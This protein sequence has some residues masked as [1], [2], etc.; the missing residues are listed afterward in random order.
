MQVSNILNDIDSDK[1]IFILKEWCQNRNSILSDFLALDSFE[2]RN[3][4]LDQCQFYCWRRILSTVFRS[5]LKIL[6]QSGIALLFW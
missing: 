3:Y 5:F 4:S 2:V 6:E 1:E